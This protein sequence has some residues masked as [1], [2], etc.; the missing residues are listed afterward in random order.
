[1]MNC[2]M[3]RRMVIVGNGPVPCEM[4]AYV[5]SADTVMRF[6]EPKESA[7][8]TGLRTDILFV[9]N[10]GKP[11]QRRLLNPDYLELPTFKA[12][13][14]VIFPYHPLII[15]RYFIKPN[16][17]SWLKGRRADFTFKALRVLGGAGKTILIL[18]PQFYEEGCRELGLDK[19]AMKKVFPSTGYFGIRYALQHFPAPAWNIEI[20]GFSWE[21]WSRHA[22]LDERRWVSERLGNDLVMLE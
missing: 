3:R 16:P 15:K 10:S 13:R 4:S 2:P 14:E 18:P 22:W 17:L 8:M 19:A 21:G 6:N 11:M 7:G 1:M 9:C 20:C 12:A 5:D